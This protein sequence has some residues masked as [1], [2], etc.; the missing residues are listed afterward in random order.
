MSSEHLFFVLA[1]F[2]KF[3]EFKFRNS[4][5]RARS[6]LRELF[7]KRPILKMNARWYFYFR[8]V[9]VGSHL[10]QETRW[11]KTVKDWRCSPNILCNKER[12]QKMRKVKYGTSIFLSIRLSDWSLFRT[13]LSLIWYWLTFIVSTLLYDVLIWKLRVFPHF[14]GTTI[15]TSA[16]SRWSNCNFESIYK[17]SAR[18]KNY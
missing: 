12:I 5:D 10:Y 8:L 1:P 16:L 3:V 18:S 17:I 11:T 7:W 6:G 2:D 15:L 13:F 9:R 14:P 4:R